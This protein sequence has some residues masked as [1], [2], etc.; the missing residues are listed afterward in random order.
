MKYRCQ[1]R[2]PC[3]NHGEAFVKFLLVAVVGVG[4]VEVKSRLEQVAPEHDLGGGF[5]TALDLVKVLT[6]HHEHEVLSL[7]VRIVGVGGH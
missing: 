2:T 1:T 4:H 3:S 5:E 6:G 7:K